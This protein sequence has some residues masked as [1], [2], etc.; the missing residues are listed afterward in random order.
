MADHTVFRSPSRYTQGRGVTAAL[1]REMV[2]LG[3]EGP[4]LIIAGKTV[5]GRLAETWKTSL[6]AA[7]LGHAVHRFGGE[8]ALAEIERVKASSRE[9]GARTIVGAGGKVLDTARP[10]AADLGLPVG[11][12]CARML[13][14]PV[15]TS[16]DSGLG[17]PCNEEA[18]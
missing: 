9:C 3:L 13:P 4:A 11:K 6:D 1:G 8:C 12:K 18:H 5:I 7:K 14:T 2:A 10:A 16:P 15:P 17:V